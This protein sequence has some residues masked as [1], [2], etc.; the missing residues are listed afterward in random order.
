MFEKIISFSIRNKPVIAIGVVALIIW[1]SY[2]L[3]QLPIDAVPDITNNQVQVVTLSPAL[4]PQEVERLITMPVELTMASIPGISEMRSMSRFGLSVVTIVFDDDVDVYWARAQVDQRLIEVQ[5]EIP[6]GA[7]TPIL[8]PVTT[9]LGEIY[10]YTLKAKP[11]YESRYSLTELRTIQDWIIR[12]RLLGTP[13][14]AD[15]SSFGGYLKQVEIALDPVRMQSTGISVDEIIIAVDRNNANGGGAYIERRSDVQYI[16]TDGIV[17][18]SQDIANIVIRTGPTQ[19]PLRVADVAT[20]RDGH[21]IRYGA[22]TRGSAGETVG[23]IVM[24]LKGAN[25]SQVISTV[26]STI[27]QIQ[28]T[29]PAGVVVEPFLDRTK[30][31]NKA[32]STVATNLIEGAL[33]VIFVLVLMLGNLRAGF[34]VASVIPLAM[35]FAV[36]MMGLFGVSGNLMSLGALDFGL[37][38]DGA[39]IIVERVLHALHTPSKKGSDDSQKIVLNASVGIRRSAAFGELIIMI[40]YIPILALVGIE[41][42]MFKPMAQTVIFAVAGA[43][44]LSTTYVPMMSALLLKQGIRTWTFADRIMNVIASAYR[45][46]RRFAMRNMRLSLLATLTCF[47]VSIAVFLNMGGEFLPQLDEGDFAIEM[48]LMTGQNLSASISSAQQA[49]GILKSTFPEVIRVVGKIGTSEIPLDPM[50]MES[51]DLIVVL[52]DKREWTSAHSREELAVKMQSALAVIPGVTFSFQQPIQMR[53]N[54]LMTGARQDVVVKVFG[55]DMDSLEAIAHTIG[56]I[57][58]RV[59]GAEDVYVEPVNGLPQVT[60]KVDRS[61]LANLGVDVHDVNTTVRAAFAGVGVGQMFEAEKRFDIVIRLDSLFRHDPEDVASLLIPARDGRRIPLLQVATVDVVLGPNQIQRENAQ[62]RITVGFNVRGRDVESIVQELEQKIGTSLKLP[63]GYYTTYGGQFENLAAAK[64]RLSL[65][66]PAALAMILFLLY[67][68][69][70]NMTHALLIFSAVPLSAIGGIAALYT[71]GMP[72]SISAGVG[73]IALFGVAVLNGIVLLGAFRSL[74]R[75]DEN[76]VRVVL[77]GTEQRLRPV[78]MTALVA[79][80]GFLPMAISTGDGAEVQRP[81]ATVVIGGL[82]TSTLLTLVIVPLL[83]TILERRRTRKVSSGSQQILAS[84]TIILLCAS[85]AMAQPTTSPLSLDSALSLARSRNALLTIARL[86]SEQ[87]SQSAAAAVELPALSITYMGGQYNALSNDNN[88][89][90][91]QTIP[92]P[93]KITSAADLASEIHHE[94]LLRQGA[95]QKQVLHDVKRAYL[96]VCSLKERLRIL[97]IYSDNAQRALQVARTRE[98]AGDGTKL[99]RVNAET[100]TSDAELRLMNVT[101]EIATAQLRLGA[102][103]GIAGPIT[104]TDSIIPKPNTTDTTQDLRES[105]RL[106]ILEQQVRIADEK[107]R[108]HTSQYLPDVSLGYFTQ[109]LIGTAIGGMPQTFATSRDRFTGFTVGLSLPLWFFSTSAR[110]EQSRLGKQIAEQQLEYGRTNLS[111]EQLQLRSA[112]EL[113][114]TTVQFYATRALAESG[115]LVSQS[116]RSYE[117]GEASWLEYQSAMQRHLSVNL[118]DIDARHRLASL[119]FQF[120]LLSGTKQ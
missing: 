41:G 83:Y 57:A 70:T 86:E 37:I 51:G 90:I 113:A 64:Q 104:T 10:Q 80:L 20:V 39:V 19:T 98:E 4:A 110:V 43:F 65:A 8:A 69:F 7:G 12:R 91:S 112:I 82:V 74:R 34:I 89:A 66:V 1:G 101:A 62:R 108:V 5:R 28:K 15:V 93:T 114:R 44:I 6:Q 81:L 50:P 16:R 36:S 119:L 42:K 71:R 49:A 59:Q 38:V 33:I 46:A 99:E 77:R 55:D 68:T 92:F 116:Q 14:V 85:S 96:D 67:F 103:C 61:A 26:T 73:F 11:G 97:T 54:E 102:I 72:F 31:V 60:I 94:A 120:E 95:L 75:T 3:Q 9:G 21:A 48:R 109:T 56:S 115:L 106:Q 27:E 29:L 111:M 40:V 18:T 53:F 25:S 30:L 63:S 88:L 76:I 52:K 87:S 24:M 117:A 47:V 78:T 32:I 22:M 118:M 84:V 107:Y 100:E 105:P 45:P 2:S 79:S 17:R 23:G 13:G 35:L 58:S